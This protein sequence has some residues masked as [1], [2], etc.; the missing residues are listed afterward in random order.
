MQK[1]TIYVYGRPVRGAIRTGSPG[2][3]SAAETGTALDRPRTAATSPMTTW[4]SLPDGVCSARTRDGSGR[5][6][7][8]PRDMTK[9]GQKCPPLVIVRYGLERCSLLTMIPDKVVTRECGA[10]HGSVV[11]WPKTAREIRV[12][13]SRQP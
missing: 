5:V 3:R 1:S 4:T 9:G 11:H 2:L 10:R 7:R 13:K 12:W 8:R 6:N